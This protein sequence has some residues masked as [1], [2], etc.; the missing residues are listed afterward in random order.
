MASLIITN[1]TDPIGAMQIGTDLFVNDLELY[2]VN[3]PICSG[4]SHIRGTYSGELTENYNPQGT[5]SSP[6]SRGAGYITTGQNGGKIVFS[7]G[8]GA[9][10]G[11]YMS[12]MPSSEIPMV[13]GGFSL[14]DCDYFS[15]RFSTNVP[16]FNTL[17]EATDYITALTDA[18]ALEYL[19]NAVNYKEIENTQDTQDYYIYNTYDTCD[20]EL[21]I[22]EYTG[23]DPTGRYE[24]IKAD[25]VVG[26]YTDYENSLEFHLLGKNTVGSVYSSINQYDVISKQSDP[27]NWTRG[28][29]YYD[30]PFYDILTFLP[31]GSYT[32]GVTLYTN[33]PIFKDRE[34]AIGNME[35]TVPDEEAI[36]YGNTGNPA[37]AQNETGQKETTTTFGGNESEN[38]FSHDYM[39]TRTQLATIGGKF[40]DTSIWQALL[41]GLKIYGNNPMDSVLGCVYFPFDLSTIATD[42]TAV[43]D[44]YFGSYKMENVSANKI[45]HR[46][47][48]KEMG[49]TFIKPTFYN[50][51]DYKAQHVY[52]YLPYCG[53]VELDINKYLNKWLKVIYM[54]D[55]HSGECEISLLADGL[56]MDTYSGQIGIKQPITYNDLS[57]Y[58]QAQVTAL[59]NGAAALIGGPV[60]GAGTGAQMGANAGPYGAIAGAAAGAT[61]GEIAGRTTAMWTGY[62]VASTKPPLF[63]KGGYSSEIGANMP[64]YCFLVFMYND[65]V[66]PENEL[67]LY[68]K[69]SEKSGNVGS[70]SGFLSV[71]YVKLQVPTATETEKEEILSLLNSGIYI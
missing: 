38:V 44:I 34:T 19:K 51:L 20:I 33:I 37:I 22:V 12:G 4:Q 17:Q 13:P 48:Y 69:P 46:S 52:L 26:Y 71:N 57:T 1:G 14:N 30:G 3:G 63:S 50:W 8:Y 31:D 65:V 58:F 68:G 47:G 28:T 16:I 70:F 55:I 59:R 42:A 24:I 10:F 27:D 66:I 67:T 7:T 61:V 45:R 53:F 35:G 39:M 9:Y 32:I 36:N 56:L 21:G 41:D 6:G 25:K 11:F 40:F 62:K 29:I 49:S 43:T 23:G 60:A 15:G 64:Q 2:R 5:T 54:V 18:E